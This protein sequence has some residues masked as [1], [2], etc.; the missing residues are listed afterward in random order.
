MELN[1]NN[2]LIQESAY[3]KH[4]LK[5]FSK[6]D[7]ITILD[8]GACE[9][10][11]S[12]RYSSIFPNSKI[13]AF[14]PLPQN[15]V[16][17]KSNISL[18]KSKNIEV[19][20]IALSN[21]VG[22]A[23]FHVSSGTPEGKEMDDWD[24]GNKSSS[25]L[26][27]ADVTEIHKWLK[28]ENKI[29][30]ETQT[31]NYF[32]KKEKIRQ[33][34]FIHMDVQ[35]AEK[36]VLE[37]GTQFLKNIKAIWLEVGKVEFYKG[38]VL[39][40]EI[41]YFLNRYNFRLEFDASGSVA[42]DLLFINNSFFPPKLSFLE[43]LRK[44]MNRSINNFEKSSYSQSGEDLIVKYI[45]DTLGIFKPTYL[46]I[47]AHHPFYLNNTFLFYQN[48]SRGINV[49]PDKELFDVINKERPQ[50][51]NLN[52][53][54]SKEDGELS[55]YKISSPTLNTFSYQEA[56]NFESE[57]YSIL[58]EI[59]IPVMNINELISQNHFDIFPDF[60]S[61][62]VEGL[63]FEIIE[64]INFEK[65]QPLVICTETI[66]FSNNGY[67]IKD[68]NIEN[69]L[70]TKGYFLYADTNINSIFVLKNKWQREFV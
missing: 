53:G 46:D 50:D 5:Y 68:K 70:V 60:L 9:G 3:I 14:E 43:R 57:G 27:P 34:D 35:G 1:I 47:G 69:F 28:F 41:E 44:K 48:G 52:K 63:D 16:K 39:Q 66:S 49:E 56:L 65:Y 18:Y 24:Y 30:V 29:T 51:I 17:I 54:V 38:Q 58:E 36:M 19:F 7:H 22:E 10:E 4:L 40:N 61:V 33:I 37:G 21:K 67:G 13:Y 59:K 8:I 11:D 42:G 64:S 25:L 12:I 15:L 31:L 26:E 2:Y 32:T 20:P 45:F 23:T 6:K 62:D 55:F